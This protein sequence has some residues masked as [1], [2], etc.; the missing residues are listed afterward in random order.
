[1]TTLIAR[2]RR[3]AFKCSWRASSSPRLQF[4]ALFCAEPP[5]AL[6]TSDGFLVSDDTHASIYDLARSHIVLRIRRDRISLD[7]SLLGTVSS[8][9]V[10]RSE[11]TRG[12]DSCATPVAPGT[13]RRTKLL[14]DG[15]KYRIV[16]VST[17]KAVGQPWSRS[18]ALGLYILFFK[19]VCFASKKK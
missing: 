6:H 3:L 9:E 10:L 14:R 13:A 4:E 12:L 16:T 1:M 8:L 7:S 19:Q 2:T 11:D 5:P 17:A 18:A 15:S